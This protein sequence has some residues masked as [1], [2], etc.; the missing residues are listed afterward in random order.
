MVFDNYAPSRDFMYL[1]ALTLGA[2]L[3]CMLNH[4]RKRATSRFRNLSVTAGLC[5]FSGF[6]AALTAAAIWSNWAIFADIPLY[7]PLGITALAMA[8]IFRF[9][10]AVGFPVFVASGFFIVW[11]GFCCLRFPAIDNPG[12]GR[13]VR[14]ENGYVQIRIIPPTGENAEVSLNY[15]PMEGKPYLEIRAVHI[16]IPGQFPFIGGQGRGI[17][18]EVLG[19]ES[20]LFSDNRVAIWFFPGTGWNRAMGRFI[21]FDGVTGSLDTNELLPGVSRAILLDG[22]GLSFR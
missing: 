12:E 6:V 7:L 19:N 3:G 16:V 9:P 8:L 13:A 1:A 5:F 17:I 15:K 22:N 21:L 11:M 10:K 4:F 2:G 20:V 18:A 14:N